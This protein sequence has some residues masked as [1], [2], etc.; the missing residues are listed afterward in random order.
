MVTLR[1]PLELESAVH[2]LLSFMTQPSITAKTPQLLFLRLEDELHPP[3]QL[4]SGPHQLLP[5]QYIVSACCACL[6]WKQMYHSLQEGTRRRVK[7]H[8]LY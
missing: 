3:P 6:T 8:P 4:V 5:L 2:E 1:R 7:I